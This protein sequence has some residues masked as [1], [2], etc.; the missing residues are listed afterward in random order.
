[1]WVCRVIL[2]GLLL[3][4]GLSQSQSSGRTLSTTA[5]ARAERSRS[6]DDLSLQRD[7]VFST[8]LFA[9][10][11]AW[12]QSAVAAQVLPESDQ[13]ILVTYRVLRG[14]ATDLHPAGAWY[15]TWPF[16]FVNYDDYTIPIFRAGAG[17]QG[18]TLCDYDGN[19]A[20]PS[21]KFPDPPQE[22]GP[23]TVPPPAGSVRPAGP[24]DTGAD[25][26]LA[27]YDPATFTAYD[28][29]QATTQRDG[30]CLSWGGGYTGTAILEAGAID[31]FDVRGD[32][33]N[34]AGV[35]SARAVGT[36]LLAGLILPED[37]EGG[38]I[39]HALAFAIPGLR[40]L[41]S[42]PYDP[43]P[44]DYVYPAATTET[45]FYNTNPSALAAGQRLR[46]TQTLVDADGNPLDEDQLAPITRMFLAALRTYGAYLVDSSG[47]FTF[48]AEDIHTAVLDLSDA[49]I[50]AL[51]G[52]PPGAPLPPGK[53][54][55][56]IVIE[57]L[58]LELEQIPFAYGPW[59]EGQDPATASITHANF[60][61][62]QPAVRPST[63]LPLILNDF[64]GTAAGPLALNQVNYWAYQIQDLSAS[65]A[66]EALAASHYD[67]LVLEPTR[68]DWSSDDKN[69]DAAGM[70]SQLKNGLASDG[71]HR[72]LV[73]AYIDIGEAEDWRWYWNW[74]TNWDCAGD[75]PA[76]WPAYVLACDPD[77]WTGNYPVAY[78]DKEWQ[79]VVIY[80]QNTGSH[81][82]RDYVSVLDEVLDDGFDGIYLDW[83]EG[84][85]NTAVIS[86]AQEAGVDPAAE[87][88]AFIGEMRD[89]A[90]A[91]DPDFVIIQQNAAALLDGHAELLDVIDA[92]AQE[93]IWY[94]G[95]ATDDW[96]DPDGYDWINDADLSDYYLGYLDQYLAA[97]TP[98]F[99]CEY[100]LSYAAA[101][102]AN[103]NAKGYAPYITRRSLSQLTT[104]PPPGY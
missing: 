40:N 47:G 22:G 6:I 12:N 92:I 74:S 93:A 75:P 58:D 97:G 28:F 84:F 78:W 31:F 67:L 15:T 100:A 43:L 29:W 4:C 102:Y 39:D 42:D 57:T 16:P 101:A 70:V 49:E 63:F 37:V 46:L 66:V 5:Q 89:Y 98:V 27:L 20:W 103:A 18:V 9:A 95:D 80:G 76:D 41:S 48:Y 34:P 59:T 51:I 73:V 79:D 69:F 68:T 90:A 65:G 81:P 91:R 11:S 72:K 55:W 77:G 82:D 96:N 52:Q 21:P 8:P 19:L 50:N 87:M 38:S 30:A 104:T 86:A 32:G 45:D 1:L 61:V 53:T 64:A 14:D 10:G 23:V 56:Q 3:G 71:V 88:I 2:L 35:A 60:E 17:Q 24:Q 54:K 26:H 25:G 7:F 85:E 13:H 33:T 36:P 62:V 94:D 99:N 83:V 44:S